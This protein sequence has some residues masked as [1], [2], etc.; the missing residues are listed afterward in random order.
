MGF[1]LWPV[2]VGGG[3]WGVGG[4][5]WPLAAKSDSLLS[6]GV[7]GGWGFKVTHA[8]QVVS[9]LHIW[10]FRTGVLILFGSVQHTYIC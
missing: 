3:V 6:H 1:N 4:S 7:G 8:S 5:A 2:V 10:R 9:T